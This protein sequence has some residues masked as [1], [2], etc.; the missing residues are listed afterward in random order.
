MILIIDD[1]DAVRCGLAAGL[2]D[3]GF[4]AITADSAET[5]AQI[6]KRAIP[7]AIVL[8]RMM[9]GVDGLTF[10]RG[11]RAAGTRIPVLMLTALGG[12]ENAIDG[13]A[14]G[15]DDY[16]AKPFRLAELILRLK[17]ITKNAPA[18]QMP[19]S[20]K[21]LNLTTAERDLLNKLASPIGNVVPAAPMTAKR[22]GD[23]LLAKANEF[24]IINVRGQG[25]RLIC[26]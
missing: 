11:I 16:L 9:V 6:L 5:G 2:R 4:A 22:L 3:A 26:V 7:D 19:E 18:M 8:D 17:N 21:L 14:G 1:D 20:L 25:Y 15:A 24:S 12:P 23:K 13:L 10:L